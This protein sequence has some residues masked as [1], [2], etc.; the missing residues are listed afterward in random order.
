[1]RD[2]FCCANWTCFYTKI[3][4]ISCYLFQWR[5][6]FQYSMS[7]L[8]VHEK[9]CNK[10][11]DLWI[12]HHAIQIIKRQLTSQTSHNNESVHIG[13]R[14]I[15]KRSCHWRYQA[16]SEGYIR[17]IQWSVRSYHYNDCELFCHCDKL[18]RDWPLDQWE[19]LVIDTGK[20][21][22]QVEWLGGVRDWRLIK[23]HFRRDC[24]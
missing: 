20:E 11:K 6:W 12:I 10:Q 15:F 1:M 9:L 2:N 3:Y 24:G 7:F 19:C 17:R 13:S 16:S 18:E 8:N 14:T 5:I 23:K 21:D 4:W 22:I